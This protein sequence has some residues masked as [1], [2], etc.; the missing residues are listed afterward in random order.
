M[1]PSTTPSIFNAISS[2]DPRC[3]NSEAMLPRN[4]KRCHS[5]MMLSRRTT[6]RRQSRCEH[7]RHFLYFRYRMKV[8]AGQHGL[9]EQEASDG[10]KVLGG[11]LCIVLAAAMPAMADEAPEYGG[12]LTYMIPAD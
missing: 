4:G 3:E 5:H 8:Q 10:T 11:R 7:D 9:R 1:P 6:L 12:I 2:P